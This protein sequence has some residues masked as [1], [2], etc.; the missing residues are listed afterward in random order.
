MPKPEEIAHKKINTQL[1]LPEKLQAPL[2]D[3]AEYDRL[4]VAYGLSFDPYD[5]GEIKK[6]G[7][8]DDLEPEKKPFE[9]A[10]PK[11]YKS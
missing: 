5:I 3:D 2:A 8:I 4:P 1:E 9:S 11:Q 7:E 10:Y 6:A